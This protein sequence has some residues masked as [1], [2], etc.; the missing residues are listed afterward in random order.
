MSEV[1]SY[2]DESVGWVEPLRYPSPC[3]TTLRPLAKILAIVRDIAGD[4][5]DRFQFSPLGGTTNDD[6]AMT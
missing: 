1:A 4:L 2:P 6:A 5:R 3:R